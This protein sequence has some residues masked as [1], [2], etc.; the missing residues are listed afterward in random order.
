M[1]DVKLVRLV[2]GEEILCKCENT[3]TGVMIKDPM[4]L[5]PMGQGKLGFAKWLPY[6]DTDGGVAVG[7]NNVMFILNPDVELKSQYTSASS[8]LILPT[9]APGPQLK[10]TG[11]PV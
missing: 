4:I 10:I 6:A 5:V 2:T 8:G 7:S 1:A 3:S 11:A 9:P